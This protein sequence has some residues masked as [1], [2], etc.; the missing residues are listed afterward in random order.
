MKPTHQSTLRPAEVY[1]GDMKKLGSGNS[2]L[3]NNFWAQTESCNVKKKSC[4]RSRNSKEGERGWR[5]SGRLAP[6]G[7]AAGGFN[8]CHPDCKRT[9]CNK[10][11][12]SE[13]LASTIVALKSCYL[14]DD[15]CQALFTGLNARTF[16][17]HFPE[18]CSST[19][20]GK[21]RNNSPDFTL[22]FNAC[23]TSP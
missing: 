17:V 2:S 16:K 9:R 10:Q 7:K 12:F 18:L 1:L 15:C 13:L 11:N 19:P 22:S 14:H 4:F 20:R 8:P 6:I 23:W 3:W 5:G 21:G